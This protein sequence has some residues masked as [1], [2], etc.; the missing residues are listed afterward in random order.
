ME[1]LHTPKHLIKLTKKVSH[2][3]FNPNDLHYDFY[4]EIEKETLI[5]SGV[6]A[7]TIIAE[8]GTLFFDIIKKKKQ[9]GYPL[10]QWIFDFNTRLSKIEDGLL[11]I[12]QILAD[13]KV[14]LEETLIRDA[15]IKLLSECTTVR[16]YFD[17]YKKNIRNAAVKAAVL[18]KLQTVNSSCNTLRQYSYATIYTVAYAFLIELELMLLLK[19]DR[20]TIR[21][22]AQQY[23]KYF[24]NCLDES[25]GGSIAFVLAAVKNTLKKLEAEFTSGDKGILDGIYNFKGHSEIKCRCAGP[26][27]QKELYYTVWHYYRATR[28][29]IISGDIKTGFSVKLSDFIQKTYL[30]TRD[31]GSYANE[32]AAENAMNNYL[33][34]TILPKYNNANIL[35]TQLLLDKA[36]MEDLVNKAKEFQAYTCGL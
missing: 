27:C 13:L 30:G 8:I 22:V 16:N 4:D 5:Y 32:A 9:T 19:F 15:E 2:P 10:G 31:P 29:Y 14:Y 7:N 34:T 33:N 3:F 26:Q 1:I 35:F 18:N 6:S 11:E 36:K 24:G 21:N 20:Q 12:K 25:K 23:C 17:Y 28:G